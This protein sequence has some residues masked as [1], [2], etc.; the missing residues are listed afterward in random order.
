MSAAF[1]PGEPLGGDAVDGRAGDGH[2][3]DGDADFGVACP[4]HAYGYH[5]RSRINAAGSRTVFR[6]PMGLGFPARCQRLEEELDLSG[7][8]VDFIAELW[9]RERAVRVRA[10]PS[11]VGAAGG[12]VVVAACA[13]EWSALAVT[14]TVLAAAVVVTGVARLDAAVRLATL[15]RLRDWHRRVG[16]PR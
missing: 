4:V 6:H 1:E 15:R 13:L 14:V 2:A 16:A 3:A 10:L 5:S 12:G 7:R 11:L 8:E 9:V